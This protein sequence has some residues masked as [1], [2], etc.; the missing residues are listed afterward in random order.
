MGSQ[1]ADGNTTDS[2]AVFR[3]LLVKIDISA[4]GIAIDTSK[5]KGDFRAQNP[6]LLRILVSY[7]RDSRSVAFDRLPCKS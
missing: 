6:D 2:V 5:D 4:Q 3:Q 1:L 7:A